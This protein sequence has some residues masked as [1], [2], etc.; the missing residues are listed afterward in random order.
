[1]N[2]DTITL[3][4]KDMKNIKNLNI[5]GAILLLIMNISCSPAMGEP[6]IQTHTH[7]AWISLTVAESKRLIAK[8][9]MEYP[10]FSERLREGQVVIARGTTNTYIAEELLNE[11]LR[12]GEYVAGH[13]LP[14]QGAAELDRSVTR[15]EIL[16]KNGLIQDTPF[17][18]A[19]KGMKAG[20][21]VLKGANIIN[22][23]KGQAGVL[24]G[25]PTGGTTGMIVPRINELDLRLIIPVGL[26]KESTQDIELLSLQTKVPHE[27]IGRAMPYIWSIEGELFTELEAIKQFADVDVIHVSSGGIGGAEGGVTLSIRGERKEVEKALEKIRSIQ[28]EPAY[29]R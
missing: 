8:G 28:G 20:D 4:V 15:S 14:E 10:P 22:Y 1:M 12:S 13:I 11:S 16:F 21:I 2:F 9:L 6:A 29:L 26:E 24:I 19:L 18:D 3:P 25:S 5:S 17:A 23:H 7:Q 27:T